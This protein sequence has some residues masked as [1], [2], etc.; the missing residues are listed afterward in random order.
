MDTKD[1]IFGLITHAEDLQT[2]AD[3]TYNESLAT[4]KRIQNL[5]DFLPDNI[6]K[7]IKKSSKDLLSHFQAASEELSEATSYAAVTSRKLKLTGIYLISGIV[8][9][10]LFVLL[11]IPFILKFF[12]HSE[13]SKLESIK[14]QISEE[15]KTF[16]YLKSH[17]IEFEVFV[18]KDGKRGIL[19]PAGINYI[20]SFPYDDGREALL[21]TP[22][23]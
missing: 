15:Q 7:H 19:L 23:Q 10:T 9:V 1:K 22:N 21:L 2:Q 13:L 4:Q 16:Q 14:H 17:N 12:Y 8:L 6:E 3:K 18:F 5:V 11:F 20:Q